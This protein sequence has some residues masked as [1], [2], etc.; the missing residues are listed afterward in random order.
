MVAI[1]ALEVIFKIKKKGIT[2]LCRRAKQQ[3]PTM[4]FFEV[5]ELILIKP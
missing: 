3:L 2:L 1:I 4:I 5:E